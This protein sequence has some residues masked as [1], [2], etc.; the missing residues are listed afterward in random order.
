MRQLTK[1]EAAILLAGALLMV[2]GAGLYVFGIQGVSPW[3]FAVGAVAFAAMQLRQTYGGRD[4]TLKRLRR[5]MSVG[6]ALFIL[7]AALMLE[8]NYHVLMPLFVKYIPDGYYHYVTYIHNNWVIIL[9][10]AA[11]IEIY[12]THRISHELKKNMP[13][14]DE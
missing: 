13:G 14:T 7:S 3:I 11:I 5:I 9:L 6:D 4:A 8:N 2:V 10:V 12:T 1:T